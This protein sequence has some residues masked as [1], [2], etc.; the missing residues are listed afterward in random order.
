MLFGNHGS[1]RHGRAPRWAASLG[2]LA[3]GFAGW[4]SVSPVAAQGQPPQTL[5]PTGVLSP[6]GV[7]G[8]SN[9]A[10]TGRPFGADAAD[11]TPQTR[12]RPIGAPSAV[13]AIRAQQ[14]SP[15]V[16]Q[17]T[18]GG[19]TPANPSPTFSPTATAGPFVTAGFAGSGPVRQAA[20][21]QAQN[22]SGMTLPSMPPEGYA[23]PPTYSPPYSPPR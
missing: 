5:S 7:P 22:G 3:C 11:D 8:P 9:I 16:A 21:M 14:T 17:P 13:D 20:M 23:V 18:P 12:L 4:L 15:R 6:S 2:G 10:V 19:P 1:Q